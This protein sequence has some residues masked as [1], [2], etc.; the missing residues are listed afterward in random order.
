MKG[1]ITS[2]SERHAR[3]PVTMPTTN[4]SL[5]AAT[6]DLLERWRI[7]DATEDPEKIRAA[8]EELAEFTRALNENRTRSGE[9]SA[10]S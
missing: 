9:P 5:D 10:R 4:G 6:L 8:E 1:Q 3:P 2:P 7:E